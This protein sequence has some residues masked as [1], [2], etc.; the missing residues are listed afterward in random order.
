MSY[1][2]TDNQKEVAVWL[3]QEARLRN[4]PEDFQVSWFLS[5]EIGIAN[6]TGESKIP[7]ITQGVLNALRA[8]DLILYQVD[9]KTHLC[10]L[11]GKI[12]EAVD[13]DFNAPDSSFVVHLTPLAD[14]TNLDQDIKDRCLPILGAGSADPKLWDTAVRTA[15]VILEERLRDV[16]GI[17]DKKRVGQQL[18][19]DLFGKDGRLADKFSISSEGQGYRNLFAG[20]VGVFRNPFG[21]RLIDPSPSNGGAIIVFINM[22]LDMLEDLR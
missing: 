3:V 14:L 7:D 16:G 1:N 6:F 13:S 15:L 17:T 11:L 4:L 20:I 9:S 8:A 22:L 12:Y 18:V 10:T 5:G 19:N 21:H 2:L